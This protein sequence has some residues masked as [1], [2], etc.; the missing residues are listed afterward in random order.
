MRAILLNPGPVSLSEQV[1]K[2]AISADLCHR[3]PEFFDLQDALRTGLNAVY[4]CDD[5]EWSPVLLGGSGTTAM[6]AMIS[7]M[8]PRDG[9]LLILENGVYGERLARIAE[10]HGIENYSVKRDWLEAW[11]LSAVQ[12]ALEKGSYTH[13]TA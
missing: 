4:G 7:S 2:A 13:V 6:E 5:G 11:D 10:L 1:R 8:I 12:E 3:E 9:R